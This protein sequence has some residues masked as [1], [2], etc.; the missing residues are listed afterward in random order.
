VFLRR[1]PPEHFDRDL[2]EFYSKLLHGISRPAFHDG[3][4]VL[5]ERTGWPDNASYQN[6]VA[7]SWLLGDEFYLIVVNLGDCSA[8]GRVRVSWTNTA[9]VTWHLVDLLSDLFYE[10]RGDEMTSQGLYVDLA[11]WNYH[12][13]HCLRADKS[14]AHHL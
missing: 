8:Q 13:F 6:L 3:E 4:W 12:F 10:R 14:N 11:P 2:S 1:R 5:C 7:W 9:G